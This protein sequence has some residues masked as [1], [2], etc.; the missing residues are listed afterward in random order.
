MFHVCKWGATTVLAISIWAITVQ[1]ARAEHAKIDLTVSGPDGQAEAS[2]DE[3]PPVGG[4]YPRHV[5]TVK[6]GDPLVLRFL[7]TDEYPH[8]VLQDVT[9][10]YFVVGIGAIGQK[11]TPNLQKNVV[12][13]GH[14]VMNMKPKSSVGAMVRFRVD[15]PG[16]YLMRVDT[17]NT[18]RDHEHF[19]AIDLEVK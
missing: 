4:L 15:T 17:L 1:A 10:R 9:V 12:T 11:E 2:T 3:E 18:Q 13:Q 7:L 5:L 16:I 6:A 14:A 8:G 19:S